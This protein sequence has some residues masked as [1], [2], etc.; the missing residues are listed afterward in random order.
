MNKLAL[1]T[2]ALTLVALPLA[3][4]PALAQEPTSQR[5]EITGA[6]Y[7]VHALCPAVEDERVRFDVSYRWADSA[8]A[9]RVAVSGR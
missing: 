5:I 2:T 8:D 7:D 1:H 9:V 3:S 4:A 6:R